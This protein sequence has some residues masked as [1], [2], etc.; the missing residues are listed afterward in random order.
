MSASGPARRDAT[1]P[2]V[3]CPY[4]LA[5][6]RGDQ[7]RPHTGR[8]GVSVV[9][10]DSNRRAASPALMPANK[11]APA[12]G[13]VSMARRLK[14]ALPKPSASPPLSSHGNGLPSATGASGMTT[15]GRC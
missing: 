3:S 9:V 1:V 10:R 8:D 15:T 12:T 11:M 4:T 7:Q 14:L 5:T 6:S 2:G 13:H